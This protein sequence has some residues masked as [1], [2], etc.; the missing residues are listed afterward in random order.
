M[1]LFSQQLIGIQQ[2]LHLGLCGLR[3]KETKENHRHFKRFWNKD[4]GTWRINVFETFHILWLIAPLNLLGEES[5]DGYQLLL[6]SIW[7]VYLSSFTL[8]TLMNT[9]APCTFAV[10]KLYLPYLLHTNRGDKDYV[11]LIE[12]LGMSKFHTEWCFHDRLSRI[13]A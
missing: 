4:D 12:C 7:L 2:G 5:E 8:K 9:R 6:F 10:C 13:F 3:E 1:W 11:L